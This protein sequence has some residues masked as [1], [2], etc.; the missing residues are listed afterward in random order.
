VGAVPGGSLLSDRADELASWFDVGPFRSSRRRVVVRTVSRPVLV[1]GSTQAGSIV[2]AARLEAAGVALA[3]RRSGGGAV[4]LQP[5]AQAW[6]DVWVPRDDPLWSAEPRRSAER[7]G[8]W[9]AAS[10]PD[11]NGPLPATVHRGPMTHGPAG[12]LVCFAG[13]GPGEVLVGERKLVGLAQWRSREGALV[14][15]CA[16]RAW[17]PG[18]IA[19]LLAPED[20]G[21]WLAG[22]L[23]ERAI[24]LEDAGAPDWEVD[25]LLTT[26]P[27]PASWQVVLA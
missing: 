26:L 1:L 4:L 5:D 15:G 2:D 3:R 24:G 20:E 22:A 14:H 7:V 25:S 13:V 19:A 9:W 17:D 12:D 21:A 6:V 27:E 11:A 23:A 16:Y 8:E 18:A 10:L